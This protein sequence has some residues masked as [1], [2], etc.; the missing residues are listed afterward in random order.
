MDKEHC[1][2]KIIIALANKLFIGDFMPT[3]AAVQKIGGGTVTITSV[4]KNGTEVFATRT[5]SQRVYAYT[6][7][8]E[9][10]T[11]N[12]YFYY[13][14]GTV[15]Q[16]FNFKWSGGTVYVAPGTYSNKLLGGN[17]AGGASPVGDIYETRTTTTTV[18]QFFK[19]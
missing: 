16:G 2:N 11:H 5:T 4:K 10:L 18:R 6:I 19:G 12:R 1:K 7:R 8:A 15:T 9:D 13:L 3:I 17:S 14:T